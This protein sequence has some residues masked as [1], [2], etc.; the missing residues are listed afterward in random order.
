M[1]SEAPA[2]EFKERAEPKVR[3]SE[4]ERPADEERDRR[5]RSAQRL[6]AMDQ[7]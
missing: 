1:P 2:E 7:G 3:R 4:E 6:G 5:E